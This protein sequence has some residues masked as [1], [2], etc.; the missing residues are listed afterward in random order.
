MTSSGSTASPRL[1][2]N[3]L[4]HEKEYAKTL[5]QALDAGGAACTALLLYQ[6]WLNDPPRPSSGGEAP[7]HSVIHALAHADAGLRGYAAAVDA[8]I[9]GLKELRDLEEGVRNL[10]RDREIL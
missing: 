1:L 2:T 6:P 8:Y 10:V 9:D 5:E 3:L 7:G 4:T